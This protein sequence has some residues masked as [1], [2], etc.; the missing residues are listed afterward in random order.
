[1]PPAD[2]IVVSLTPDEALVLFE[3]LQR[4]DRT[5][6]LSIEHEAENRALWA[7]TSGLE[8]VLAEPFRGDYLSLLAL[9]RSRL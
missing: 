7:L 9:A 2:E 8:K 4:F 5:G 1:M 3:L 6:A